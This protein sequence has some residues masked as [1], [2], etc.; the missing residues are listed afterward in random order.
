MHNILIDGSK[1]AK[2]IF[3]FAHGAGSPMDSDFMNSVVKYLISNGIMTVRFEFLYMQKKKNGIKLFPDKI[4][5]LSE[6]FISII[7]YVKKLFL[8]KNIWI[9]GKSLGGRVA[10]IVS[11][12]VEINGVIVFGYPFHSLKNPKNIR[13]EVLRQKGPPVLIL[14]GDRDKM[15]NKN[16]VI[17]YNLKNKA[18]ILFLEG[19]D[20]SFL[21]LN[22]SKF[23][24]NDLIKLACTEANNFI[25]KN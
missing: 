5:K 17:S 1:E 15:G 8:N 22:T 24:Q 6:Y 18:K 16:E 7:H 23:S 3:I 20:H 11:K 25:N 14:Q 21:T 9:G 4:E 12:K 10:C 13:D 2:N 19:G